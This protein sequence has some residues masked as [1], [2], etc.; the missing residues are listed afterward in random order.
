MNGINISMSHLINT[1]HPDHEVKEKQDEP[2]CD[3][4]KQM[5]HEDDGQPYTTILWIIFKLYY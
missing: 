1:P 4:L 3:A 2:I 5:I